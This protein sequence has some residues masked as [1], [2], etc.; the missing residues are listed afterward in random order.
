VSLAPKLTGPD[1]APG[2]GNAAAAGDLL[3]D[4]RFGSESYRNLDVIG[5]FVKG[6]VVSLLL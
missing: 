5:S 2:V 3:S 1:L 6:L 4:A